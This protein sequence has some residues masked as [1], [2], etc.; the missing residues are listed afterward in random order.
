MSNPQILCPSAPLTEGAL[1]YGL[2]DARGQTA[3]GQTAF[4]VTKQLL[5]SLP[6]KDQAEQQYRF[7]SPC[8]QSACIHW[9]GRCD[10]SSR[11]SLFQ[12]FR[13]DGAQ[14]GLPQCAIRP[15][16]RWFLQDGPEMCSRCEIIARQ[17]T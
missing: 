16:C 10:L 5:L 17:L 15:Q 4:P 9:Q 13:Q 11:L 6:V 8:A 1:L 2:V 7:A 14:S 3:Y 12:A